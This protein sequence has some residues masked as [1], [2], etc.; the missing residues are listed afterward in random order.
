VALDTLVTA[1]AQTVGALRARD[2]QLQSLVA[3]AAQTFS[4]FA[5]NAVALQSGIDKMPETL[6]GARQTLVHLDSSLTGLSALTN[7]VA[8]GAAG[9]V[10]VAPHL[11]AMLNTLIR[12]GPLAR[13]TLQNGAQQLPSVTRFL[14]SATPFLPNLAAA[15]GR[16]AP[17][18]ACVRP[19]APEIGGYLGT[20]QQG[21][22]DAVGHFARIDLIQ[23]PVMPGTTLTSA[24]A[25]AQSHG[26]LQ[27]AFPRPPGLN[28]GRPWFQPQCGAG[29]NALNPTLDPEAGK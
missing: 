8:P 14:D 28:A 10:Q 3:N 5:D 11:T 17:M 23:T 2:P 9:L 24:Q 12:V 27:Y 16:L 21:P 6:S 13:K 29:P 1:G 18:L 7:D 20:W 19:Y 22:V 25:V 15:L 26:A 4:V